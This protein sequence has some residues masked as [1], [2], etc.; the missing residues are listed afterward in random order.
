MSVHDRKLS[1]RQSQRHLLGMHCVHHA[2]Q[3]TRVKSLVLTGT[4]LG[5]HS[6]FRDVEVEAQMGEEAIRKILH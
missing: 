3:H 1:S 6:H 4:F 2:R 5:V